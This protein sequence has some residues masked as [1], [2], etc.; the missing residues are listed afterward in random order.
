MLR[1]D[2]TH[3]EPLSHEQC[4]EVEDVVN[5]QILKN[6][7]LEVAEHSREEARTLGIKALFDEK[8]GEVVRAVSVPGFSK[9][10]C[11]GLHVRSTGEIGLFKII[12][13]ESVGSGTR[14]VFA[15]TGL[16]ALQA[17]QRASLL[18]NRVTEIL[19]ADESNLTDKAKELL[20]EAKHS[21]R[22]LQEEQA[23]VLAQS[24]E[25]TLKQE[26]VGG[27]LLQ[28]G[29]FPS[30]SPE[31]LRD[32]GDK[33]KARQPGTV[34]LMASLAGEDCQII[35]MADDEAVRRGVDAGA[36]VKEVAALLGGRG[37]GR[38]NMAQGGGKIARLDEALAE[39][40]ALLTAQLKGASPKRAQPKGA[41]PQ[42]A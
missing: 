27:I 35:V 8:Y 20:E 33:A 32:V 37:G 17:F 39:V 5:G 16:N 34:V 14:R 12:R 10:L 26:E 13:E 7:P 4:W 30:A 38:P 1:F 18:L 28:T 6:T 19:S 3:H 36:L 41:R 40:S 23:K 22:R 15:L 24:A 2:Y 25:S 21:R 29:K 31:T 42:K 11:G 9:E